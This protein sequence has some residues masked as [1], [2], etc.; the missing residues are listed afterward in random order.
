MTVRR[1]QDQRFGINFKPFGFFGL[2]IVEIPQQNCGDDVL[3]TIV[4][5]KSSSQL[6]PDANRSDFSP[7]RSLSSAVVEVLSEEHRMQNLFLPTSTYLRDVG[8][9]DALIL[10][11]LGYGCYGRCL[12][13]LLRCFRRQQG[14]A[15]HKCRPVTPT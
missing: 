9:F 15:S 5:E 6:M 3:H 13:V 10:P 11:R 2:S 1:S 7:A 12:H 4:A 14:S 8:C